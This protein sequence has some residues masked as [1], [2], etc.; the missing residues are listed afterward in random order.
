MSEVKDREHSKFSAS[1]SERWLNCSASVELEEKSPP[2]KDT[3][4]SL[5]GTQAHDLLEK[6]LNTLIYPGNEFGEKEIWRAALKECP[7]K[8]IIHIRETVFA[9]QRI[10]KQTGGELFSEQRI[11]QSFIHPEMFGTGDVSIV[12]LFGELHIID[13]KYG[14]GHIVNPVGSTQLIQYALGIAYKYDWNFEKVIVH[15]MQ[16]RAG[17]N[18]HKFWTLPIRD[19]KGYWLKHFQAGVAK[20][21]SP[22]PE[23]TPGNW[24]YWC[25]AKAICPAKKEAH[26]GKVTDIFKNTP[27]KGNYGKAS[28]DKN[29]HAK[30]GQASAKKES[31]SAIKTK[32]KKVMFTKIKNH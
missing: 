17:K 3:V 9:I 22:N 25:R 13:L 11:S 1:G 18:W 12:Q 27:L 28:N 10:W 14:Q 19:L 2:S 23:A 30:S 8:M 24:C 7:P 32:T 4:W 16:P 6:W 29:G 21:E 20:V 5:E 15:I 31:Q 26:A